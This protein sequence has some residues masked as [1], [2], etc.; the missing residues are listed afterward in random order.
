MKL[1]TTILAVLMLTAVIGCKKEAAP[2]KAEPAATEKT[3]TAVDETPV[4]P[5]DK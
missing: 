3:D 5:S 4:K 2:A 1:W